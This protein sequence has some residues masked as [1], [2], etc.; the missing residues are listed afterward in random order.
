[1]PL[2]FGTPVL[3]HAPPSCTHPDSTVCWSVALQCLRLLLSRAFPLSPASSLALGWRLTSPRMPSPEACLPTSRHVPF[4]GPRAPSTPTRTYIFPRA[5]RTRAR[6]FQPTPKFSPASP[7][8]PLSASRSLVP[9][10]SPPRPFS[11]SPFVAFGLR[12]ASRHLAALR[13]AECAL[14][15]SLPPPPP[16]RERVAHDA[17]SSAMP[18]LPATTPEPDPPAG[19]VDSARCANVTPIWMPESMGD[20]VRFRAASR[21]RRVRSRCRAP[22]GSRG[23]APFPS[24]FPTTKVVTRHRHVEEPSAE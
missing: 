23:L 10:R 5:L 22:W 4:Y 8:A 20:A 1:M 13:R 9:P 19:S 15:F 7:Q 18:T 17:R 2:P 14:S 24:R 3:P 21:D 11:S 6:V 16:R 12:R